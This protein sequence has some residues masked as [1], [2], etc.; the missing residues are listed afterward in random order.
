LTALSCQSSGVTI[1]K[2]LGRLSLRDFCRTGKWLKRFAKPRRLLVYWVPHAYGYKSMNVPFCLWIWFR[3]AWHRDRVELMVQECFLDFTRRSW[4]QSAAA[5]VHRVMTIILLNA[6]DY[7]WVALSTYEAR[8]RPY[9]LGR[10]VP[11]RWLPV[12]SNVAV[13]E[14][15][16]AVSR[17]RQRLAPHGILIGHFGTFGRNITELVETIVPVL[18]HEL[19]SSL[20]L[21]GS[22]S[23]AFRDR[24]RQLN[25]DLAERIHATGYLDDASLS[26]YLSACD[27]MIQPYPD[28]LTARRGSALA[29]LAHGCPI[30][31]NSTDRTE[32]L[33]SETGSVVLSSLSGGAFLEAARRLRE[34]SRER[35][36]VSAAAR[37]T[38]RTYFEPAHMISTIWQVN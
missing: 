1:H 12:P 6:A 26:C 14:S 13:I 2:T 10:R 7:A 20:V 23:E 30:I 4:R 34:D 28:G 11:F 33:W 32:P 37:Q 8:L 9:T 24:L 18:L 19:D 17:I 35:S 16:E 22:G 15:P 31:T 27:L 5:L 21:L 36:R 25:P 29:P 38:Y 3:S